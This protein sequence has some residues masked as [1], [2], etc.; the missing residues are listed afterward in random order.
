VIPKLGEACFTEVGGGSWARA[1]HWT[2]ASVSWR[3]FAAGGSRRGAA[4]QFS[5]SDSC[6]VKLVART[7]RTGSAAPARQ[8]RPPGGGKLGAHRG[9]L[10]AQVQAKSDITMPELATRLLSER[11]V[12][13]SPAIAGAM[14]GRVYL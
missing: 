2:F 7:E 5:V 9:F 13:A 1:I 11:G 10:I 14:C 8:G 3:T 4:R 6:A 12:A